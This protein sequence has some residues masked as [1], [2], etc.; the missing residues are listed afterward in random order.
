MAEKDKIIEQKVR[1]N[2]FFDF[3]E[4]YQFVYRYMV[5]EG[6]DVEEQKYVENVAGDS[7]NI[8]VIWVASKKISDYFK[9]EV[10]FS[11]RVLGL[12]SVEVDKSGQKLKMNMGSI[13]IKITG[14]LVKDWESTWE[15]N[16]TM[17][18]L[19][20]VYDKYIIEGRIKKY[21]KKLFDDVND[22]TE[23]IKAFFAI[24]GMK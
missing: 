19:R 22:T 8:E 6:Y 11:W 2:G 21:E 3:K 13:E 5:E 24:E 23:Q 12:K 18:F 14:N 7:K 16:P 17:K 1:Y 4:T 10:K 15:N 9:N 20:G